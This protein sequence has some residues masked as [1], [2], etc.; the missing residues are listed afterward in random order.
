M[1]K[2]SLTR[3]ALAVL[4]F[5]MVVVTLFA[6][7]NPTSGGGT[8]VPPQT[9]VPVDPGLVVDPEPELVKHSL[10]NQQAMGMVIDSMNRSKELNKMD[11][12]VLDFEFEIFLDLSEKLVEQYY[13]IQVK[14]SIDLEDD[15]KS[16]LQ[17]EIVSQR[18]GLDD[19]IIC[20]FYAKD[21]VMYIDTRGSA[22]PQGIHVFKVE[23][24]DIAWLAGTLQKT[25]DQLALADFM[26]RFEISSLLSGV[27]LGAFT[28]ILSGIIG[29]N[30]PTVITNLVQKNGSYYVENGNGLVTVVMPTILNDAKLMGMVFGVL[31]GVLSDDIFEVIELIFGWDAATIF[32]AA[33]GGEIGVGLFLRAQIQDDSF[34]KMSIG[35]AVND[36][37]PLDIDVGVKDI[38]LGKKPTFSLPDFTNVETKSYSF[39]TLNLDVELNVKISETA[40]PYTIAGIDESFGNLISGL[41]AGDGNSLSFV[42]S[43]GKPIGLGEKEIDVI[44]DV[45]IKLRV[46]LR[47][48]IDLKDNNNTKILLEIIGGQNNSVR[49]GV[50]YIGSEEAAYI[51]L[52]GMGSGRYKVDSYP[53]QK[54]TED[55]N[56]N[57]VQRV[58]YVEDEKG[59]YYLKN[60]EYVTSKKIPSG[61][62]LY[63]QEFYYDFYNQATDAGMKRYT[64]TTT[65]VPLNLTNIIKDSLDELIPTIPS[66]YDIVAGATADDEEKVY[67]EVYAD[68][69]AYI[70][71]LLN[72]GKVMIEHYNTAG[73]TAGETENKIDAIS[74]IKLILLDA[75]ITRGENKMSFDR[76][77]ISLGT[78][79][80]DTLLSA[81]KPGLKLPITKL[82]IDIDSSSGPGLDGI[83]IDAALGDRTAA[84]GSPDREKLSL[85]IKILTEYGEA[86]DDYTMPNVNDPLHP[87]MLL[88]VGK[89]ELGN[90]T[91]L[92]TINLALSGQFRLQLSQG[93]WNLSPLQQVLAGLI[94]QLEVEEDID[95]WYGFD[96]SANLN[97]ATIKNDTLGSIDAKIAIT[98]NPGPNQLPAIIV[99]LVDGKLYIDAEK[100]GIPKIMLD[101]SKIISKNVD[102][103]KN[104]PSG[105]L[106]TA[107]AS[108]I[109]IVGLLAGILGGVELDGSNG[110]QLEV[111]LATNL[112][113]A[114]IGALVPD[115]GADAIA[116][117]DQ[118]RV[119]E[120]SGIRLYL[121]GLNLSELELNVQLGLETDEESID[122]G[123]GLGHIFLGMGELDLVP[124]NASSYSDILSELQVYLGV[125]GS[126][127]IELA[128]GEI[129]LNNMIGAL[130][131]DLASGARFNPYIDVEEDI[132]AGIDLKVQASLDLLNAPD[133]NNTQIVIEA[134]SIRTGNLLLGAYYENAN[135][136]ADLS[137]LGFEKFC[138]N[139]DLIE[140]LSGAIGGTGELEEPNALVTA[141][142]KAK[143]NLQ[144]L[145]IAL[146]LSKSGLQ[147]KVVTGLTGLIVSLIADSI[148]GGDTA[149][150]WMLA[151]LES[152]GMPGFDLPEIG[153]SV[154]IDL[155]RDSGKP[156]LNAI[157]IKIDVTASKELGADPTLSIGLYLGGIVLDTKLRDVVSESGIERSQFPKCGMLDNVYIDV[158]GA[159]E[160]GAYASDPE[161]MN[162]SL[163]DYMAAFA[164]SMGPNEKK[165]E[166]G[167]PVLDADG[168]P[169]IEDKTALYNL[170]CAI[171]IKFN[172]A[173]DL[174]DVIGFRIAGNLAL[175]S[176]LMDGDNMMPK[177]PYLI[178]GSELA[179][180]LYNGIVGKSKKIIGIYLS[181]GYVYVHLNGN[182]LASSKLKL[183]VAG[184]DVLKTLDYVL[185]SKATENDLTYSE[186]FV[187]GSYN[188]YVTKNKSYFLVTP[189]NAEAY[190]NVKKYIKVGEEYVV[191]KDATAEQKKTAEGYVAPTYNKYIKDTT[192]GY[193]LLTAANAT[194]YADTATYPRY[195]KMVIGSKNESQG[196]S[197]AADVDVRSIGGLLNGAIRNISI[198]NH[199]ISINLG[200]NLLG[201]VIGMAMNISDVNIP[202]LNEENSYIKWDYGNPEIYGEGVKALQIS[203]G[204]DPIY[205]RISLGGFKFGM[206]KGN[207]LPDELLEDIAYDANPDNTEK[208]YTSLLDLSNISLSVEVG[209]D[210]ELKESVIPVGGILSALDPLL[211]LGLDLDEG[212]LDINV[213]DDINY[214]LRIYVQTNFNL[215]D[216]N[217]SQILLEIMNEPVGEAKRKVLGVY[218]DGL[219]INPA[220]TEGS[221]VSKYLDPV[222]YIDSDVLNIAKF[223]LENFDLLGALLQGELD[224]LLGKLNKVLA[225]GASAAADEPMTQEEV[226]DILFSLSEHNIKIILTESIIVGLLK[227]LAPDIASNEGV[228][229]VIEELRAQASVEIN[230][231]P[232]KLAVRIDTQYLALG[233]HI[234]EPRVSIDPIENIFEIALANRDQYVSF[235]QK[236]LSV[237]I[238]LAIQYKFFVDKGP[239]NLTSILEDLAMNLDGTKYIE[240]K[241]ATT[242]NKLNAE[243]LTYNRYAK[244]S[245]NQY[246]L[247]ANAASP[248]IKTLGSD[249][250]WSY[251]L[252]S[253]ASDEQKLAAEGF[254]YNTYVK[255]SD[256][257]YTKT[258]SYSP[259]GNYLKIS[260]SLAMVR[261]LLNAINLNVELPDTEGEIR[262][263]LVANILM[264]E[265]YNQILVSQEVPAEGANGN[266]WVYGV[267]TGVKYNADAKVAIGDG[268][269]WIGG[270]PTTVPYNKDDTL[271][272][273]S[274]GNWF[275]KK[276]DS[277]TKKETLY[278]TGLPYV[279]DQ[280]GTEGNGNW[281]IDGVDTG[282]AKR[283]VDILGCLDVGVFISF[284]NGNK[285]I[286]LSLKGGMLYV[287]IEDI[288]G[289][290]FKLNLL[291]LIASIKGAGSASAQGNVAVS[292][293]QEVA[294]AAAVNVSDILNNAISDITIQKG[295]GLD[296]TL[297]YQILAA[298]MSSLV[299]N[300]FG[301]DSLKH[302][303]LVDETT[304]SSAYV[305]IG[306][307]IEKD[308]KDSREYVKL[309]KVADD[310]VLFDATNPDHAAITDCR[311]ELYDADVHGSNPAIFKKVRHSGISYRKYHAPTGGKALYVGFAFAN[312]FDLGIL[313]DG[314]SIGADRKA[315]LASPEEDFV[316]VDS[317][318]T[319]KLTIETS[320]YLEFQGKQEEVVE[321]GNLL[322]SILEQLHQKKV[323]E[324]S[325]KDGDIDIRQLGDALSAAAPAIVISQFYNKVAINVKAALVLDELINGKGFLNK[326]KSSEFAIQ[327]QSYNED[328]TLKDT[329]LGLY[330]ADQC[331]Y[332]ERRHDTSPIIR[333]DLAKLLADPTT[334]GGGSAEADTNALVPTEGASEATADTTKKGDLNLILKTNGLYIEITTELVQAILSSLLDVEVDLTNSVGDLS[335]NLAIT[336]AK[337][338]KKAID[339]NE[340]GV[341]VSI[342]LASLRLAIG[343][344]GLTIG[345]LNENDSILPTNVREDAIPIEE[346]ILDVS[347]KVGLGVNIPNNVKISDV[348]KM[349]N[350]DLDF[351]DLT[352]DV[353]SG[354]FIGLVISVDASLNFGNLD[355]SEAIVKITTKIGKSAT[356]VDIV[357]IYLK[358]GDVYADLSNLLG[359]Q[360]KGKI[361]GLKLSDL[362]GANSIFDLIGGA[363]A[364]ASADHGLELG[365]TGSSIAITITE[366]MVKIL[367]GL[368]LPDS[369][370]ANIPLSAFLEIQYLNDEGKLDLEINL[371]ATISKLL[372]VDLSIY[373]INFDFRAEDTDMVTL[374]AD[375]TTYP[376]VIELGMV[377]QVN[378]EGEPI[379]ENGKQVT[380]FGIVSI[381]LKS[382]SIGLDIS[383]NSLMQAGA[384]YSDGTLAGSTVA[385]NEIAFTALLKA[386]FGDIGNLYGGMFLYDEE[387]NPATQMSR[388]LAL[389]INAEIN[390]AG[391]IEI[392]QSGDIAK[393]IGELLQNINASIELVKKVSV[394]SG[395]V[396]V[397]Q[398]ED[399][400]LGI[401]LESGD[402]YVYLEGLGMANIH[403]EH[404]FI[405]ELISALSSGSAANDN[406]MV[407]AEEKTSN[408]DIGALLSG[409]IKS[410]TL[411]N[412]ALTIVLVDDFIEPLLKTL[413]PDSE[414]VQGLD[415]PNFGAYANGNRVMLDLGAFTDR[416]KGLVAI[417]LQF[418]GLNV[419]IDVMAPTVGLHDANST[420]GVKSHPI[421]TKNEWVTLGEGTNK[422]SAELA[423]CLSLGLTGNTPATGTRLGDILGGI[424]G[425]L[426]TRLILDHDFII[427]IDVKASLELE[428]DLVNKTFN[429]SQ[430]DLAVLLSKMTSNTPSETDELL[431]G[432][433]Y[434]D[435]NETAYIDA[436]HFFQKY[437]NGS[438]NPFVNS[439]ATGKIAIDGIKITDL[440]KSATAS[441]KADESNAMV[442]GNGATAAAEPNADKL[443]S[444][445]AAWIEFGPD[446]ML[447]TVT[448]G[449]IQQ[450]LALA[451]PDT[452]LDGMLPNAALRVDARVNPTQLLI[453]VDI[454]DKAYNDVI[455]VQI[456]IYGFDHD[457]HGGAKRSDLSVHNE[458]VSVLNGVDLTVGEGGFRKIATLDI[459]SLKEKDIANGI[460][461]P[462]DVL[463][464]SLALKLGF[465]A[466]QMAGD[467]EIRDWSKYLA[468]IFGMDASE[469]DILIDILGFEDMASNSEVKI[470]IDAAINL[471]NLIDGFKLAGTEIQV[472]IETYSDI[473]SSSLH[474]NGES[475]KLIITLIG[476]E[477][478]GKSGIY[479][480]F[481]NYRN[482]GK[483]KISLDLMGLIGG[484]GSAEADTGILGEQVFNIL[485]GLIASVELA[486]GK[487]S[488]NLAQNA[489]A[490]VFELLLP[491][492]DLGITPPMG[493]GV[494]IDFRN[495]YI[496][497]NLDF[498]ELADDN[499]TPR[500]EMMRI[501]LGVG[502]ISLNTPDSY[503]GGS[504]IPEI[505]RAEYK[506]LTKLKID[507]DLLGELTYTGI[508]SSAATPPV[509]LSSLFKLIKVKGQPL[510][511]NPMFQLRIANNMGTTY[512]I[513]THIHLDLENF[514][515]LKISL[516]VWDTADPDNYAL[517]IGAYIDGYD[518]YLDLSSLG[519]PRIKL[520]G[521]NL[522]D[523][524]GNALGGLLGG[525]SASASANN[526]L[527]TS[528]D[529]G[530]LGD[531]ILQGYPLPYIALV[532]RP[533]VFAIGINAKMIDAIVKMATGVESDEPYLPDFGDIAIIGDSRTFFVPEEDA[534]EAEKTNIKDRYA[535]VLLT[536]GNRAQYANNSVY[537]KVFD[538]ALPT[539]YNYIIKGS[540]KP[541]A[542]LETNVSGEK[543]EYVLVPYNDI[544]AGTKYV[545]IGGKLLPELAIRISEGFY[546]TIKLN[547]VHING[548]LE[549]ANW[550]TA[551]EVFDDRIG[552]GAAY[553]ADWAEAYNIKTGQIGLEKVNLGLDIGLH[554]YTQE[555]KYGDADYAD[556]F[557]FYLSNLLSSLL[558]RHAA[559]ENGTSANPY[560]ND[561]SFVLNT[562]DDVIGYILKVRISADLSKLITSTGFNIAGLLESEILLE[563]HIDG[564]FT[565]TLVLGVYKQANDDAFYLDLKQLGLPKIKLFGLGALLA[566]I[567][568]AASDL[569]NYATATEDVTAPP[570][571]AEIA[572]EN[573][574]IEIALEMEVLRQLFKTLGLETADMYFQQGSTV[575]KYTAIVLRDETDNVKMQ[576][577]L[578][579]LDTIRL[580]V[581][582]AG[583][584]NS[585]SLEIGLD[586]IGTVAELEIGN[587]NVSL[588]EGFFTTEFDKLNGD[589][590]DDWGA[591]VLSDINGVS[592][593]NIVTGAL[594]GLDLDLSISLNKKISCKTVNGTGGMSGVTSSYTPSYT[595]IRITRTNG[596]ST[597]ADGKN[598]N[599][600]LVYG[601]KLAVNVDINNNGSTR[602]AAVWLFNNAIYGDLGELAGGLTGL[603]S[604]FYDLR[605][606]KFTDLNIAELVADSGTT[607]TNTQIADPN[608]KLPST[609]TASAEEKAPVLDTIKNYIKGIQI[610]WWYNT[611]VA[612]YGTN[613]GT[614]GDTAISTI[615]VDLAPQGINEL[616]CF[617]YYLLFGLYKAG[618]IDNLDINNIPALTNDGYIGM[619]EFKKLSYAT[620]MQIVQNSDGSVTSGENI[621]V[622]E[623]G[624]KCTDAYKACPYYL[625]KFATVLV[626]S[627]L[628]TTALNGILGN[629]LA[630]G[631]IITEI[632][633]ALLPIP[634]LDQNKP[635]YVEIVLDKNSP[636][637]ILREVG[638][639]INAQHYKYSAAT[640]VA[641]S[642]TITKQ[643]VADVDTNVD[644]G[645]AEVLIQLNGIFMRSVSGVNWYNNIE[646]EQAERLGITGV[647]SSNTNPSSDF[648]VGTKAYLVA[649]A[650]NP[651]ELS[652]SALNSPTALPQRVEATFTNYDDFVYNYT[653]KGDKDAMAGSDNDEKA[654]AELGGTKIIWDVSHVNLV[655]GSTDSYIYGYALNKL[656]AK[657]P[658]KVGTSTGYMKVAGYATGSTAGRMQLTVSDKIVINN[659]KTSLSEKSL[660][661][662]PSVILIQ[663]NNGEYML[664]SNDC[665]EAGVWATKDRNIVPA[666]AYDVA[667]INNSAYWEF[668]TNGATSVDLSTFTKTGGTYVKTENGVEQKYVLN[669][670]TGEYQYWV[671][672]TKAMT[673]D[674]I[675]SFV[676][677]STEVY[678]FSSYVYD[679]DGNRVHAMASTPYVEYNGKRIHA[680]NG[681]FGWIDGDKEAI[682]L[683]GDI[684]TSFWYKSGKTAKIDVSTT[685]EY[686]NNNVVRGYLPDDEEKFGVLNNGSAA[687]MTAKSVNIVENISAIDTIRVEFTS[688]EI[689]TLSVDKSK[690]Q[691]DFTYDAKKYYKGVKGNAIATVTYYNADGSLA[692]KQIKIPINVSSYEVVGLTNE[693]VAYSQYDEFTKENILP[694]EFSI[695]L[696]LSAVRT[697]A[698]TCN[699]DDIKVYNSYDAAGNPIYDTL[700]L[701]KN[702]SVDSNMSVTVKGE[703]GKEGLTKQVFDFKVQITSK[704]VETVY[705]AVHKDTN[706]TSITTVTAGFADGT[707]GTLDIVGDRTALDNL[708][709]ANGGIF[710]I[711]LNV[712][713]TGRPA[714]FNQKVKAVVR[715]LRDPL[716][717][718][719]V[720]YSAEMENIATAESEPTEVEA[721]FDGEIVFDPLFDTLGAGE[722][723][724]ITVGGATKEVVLLKSDKIVV[725]ADSSADNV[726]RS[727][728]GGVY[729]NATLWFVEA[730]VTNTVYKVSNSKLIVIDRQI[731]GDTLKFAT[732]PTFNPYFYDPNP[733]SKS[734]SFAKYATT[735]VSFKNGT[736][737]T[738]AVNWNNTDVEYNS[739]AYKDFTAVAYYGATAGV[740]KNVGC[741]VSAVLASKFEPNIVVNKTFKV[742]PLNEDGTYNKNFDAR[743]LENYPTSVTI[744]NYYQGEALTLNL[745]WNLSTLKYKYN[746]TSTPVEVSVGNEKGGYQ[747]L[748]ITLPIAPFV[749]DSD[750][751]WVNDGVNDATVINALQSANIDPFTYSFSDAIFANVSAL[752]NITV[753]ANGNVDSSIADVKW[754]IKNIKPTYKGG[755]LAT[756]ALFFKYELAG[757]QTR[758][759]N[760]KFV[761]REL[762]AVYDDNNQLL[763]DLVRTI[764][765]YDQSVSL[766]NTVNAYFKKT[767]GSD[768]TYETVSYSTSDNG[769]YWSKAN[770]RPSASGEM[771]SIDCRLTNNGVTIVHPMTYE[772]DVVTANRIT[773]WG[774][775]NVVN[776]NINNGVIDAPWVINPLD[777]T[778][779][780]H[781]PT[782][783]NVK[784]VFDTYN[785]G[786]SIIGTWSLGVTSFTIADDGAGNKTVVYK[787]SE[788]A[789]PK[790][791]TWND[792]NGVY[793]YEI[794]NSKGVFDFKKN[795]DRYT[796]NA[797]GTFVRSL[798][799]VESKGTYTRV[800]ASEGKYTYTLT[801]G[802]GAGAVTST[803]TDI[804]PDANN[805]Y[806]IFKTIDSNMVITGLGKGKNFCKTADTHK[807]ESAELNFGYV[808]INM[809][810]GYKV[811]LSG[812]DYEALVELGKG[813]RIKLNVKVLDRTFT[814]TAPTIA[815]TA[816]AGAAIELPNSINV[817]FN[818]TYDGV[819]N[820][821]TL[822][823]HWEIV[824]EYL[825]TRNTTAETYVYDSTYNQ[826]RVG[827][828]AVTREISYNTQSISTVKKTEYNKA[829]GTININ[830]GN[831]DPC[832]YTINGYVGRVMDTDNYTVLVDSFNSDS[833]SPLYQN[834][835]SATINVGNY[836]NIIFDSQ[837]TGVWITD[838]EAG[839]RQYAM[840]AFD[841]DVS[842]SMRIVTGYSEG[843]T[844][845]TTNKTATGTFELDRVVIGGN[846]YAMRLENNKLYVKMAI[847]AN[848]DISA[849]ETETVFQRK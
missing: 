498:H 508:R 495:L 20:G 783:K 577:P 39:T 371:N 412:K 713:K 246:I 483:H 570:A 491:D 567:G 524:L 539:G 70:A 270:K 360:A 420:S 213:K 564:N 838:D 792:T 119:T 464:V 6:A 238:D 151:I 585:I 114:L 781:Y 349:F 623:R 398:P 192:L 452:D 563:L 65:Q 37:N 632:I 232:F 432:I 649:D 682:S 59:K 479:I 531:T 824:K 465:D 627:L 295:F 93:N 403:I 751:A 613:T 652:S 396:T 560:L 714:A 709:F 700:T 297:N 66:L 419:G 301:A 451:L 678:N 145:Q 520:G 278:D 392:I 526:A 337:E 252:E 729:D 773:Q 594:D 562:P 733:S 617:V 834:K 26:N 482:K 849:S 98:K 367:L 123:I 551:Q 575:Q 288:G 761:E 79:V 197:A 323:K 139:I 521:V 840:L 523:I 292:T 331:L 328:G 579:N 448:M 431:L 284:D 801:Y 610:N 528:S 354:A 784:V 593:G 224:G 296:V 366:E 56:G 241:S 770:F 672:S 673:A 107:E 730:G 80:I 157:S 611:S 325:Y 602:H 603:V 656:V 289:Q 193:V 841:K 34:K 612:V 280:K 799:G 219:I 364:S 353:G 588:G 842:K 276:V 306:D 97:L 130:L 779:T 492:Q 285:Q 501:S 427:G 264:E 23:N 63:S 121:D 187:A 803:L 816:T 48:E 229:Q 467:G 600:D 76:I 214:N 583:K 787:A 666:A 515:N 441:A 728:A 475:G 748:N 814:Y 166:N 324:G 552:T 263:K 763:I 206:T 407:T 414:Y 609:E 215:Q 5:L 1:K 690:W 720:A 271:E 571:F 581:D 51:D 255:K 72:S 459:D 212:A 346:M 116:A 163:K 274:N 208:R 715:V 100:I 318:T 418:Y 75:E 708:N 807:G 681:S 222:L 384:E 764:N 573:G 568:S 639:H 460:K 499:V 45:I 377:P 702:V 660:T 484:L 345:I 789:T 755:T 835:F 436:S 311:Y 251:V 837:F 707:V 30:V 209:L 557:Q 640:P 527:S 41:L 176:L 279:K 52:S 758:N 167:N 303:Y 606:M 726:I 774:N 169:V 534:S 133:Y 791:G 641:G 61:V 618:S 544:G 142:E 186:G 502:F 812:G 320:I 405:V 310:Y 338:G 361:T 362:L 741:R 77:F 425:D 746:S 455:G 259:N 173:S 701:P 141:D 368:L 785:F 608:A 94:L 831:A 113:S 753:K 744:D 478:D 586:S 532:F 282:I 69:A 348:L 131:V 476:D 298:L 55:A 796:F 317:A 625:Q 808:G 106:A 844:E 668:Y 548:Y 401:Y 342:N 661:A 795:Y 643:S 472:T 525:S 846:T 724:T 13:A 83:Y 790:I 638:I 416:T 249:Q 435:V 242:E 546:G 655:P 766:P 675:Y 642:T 574:K 576:I 633:T 565:N 765:V 674:G 196:A 591:I 189:T 488:V 50:Y 788:T 7:C 845:T 250:T 684:E 578:P 179:I 17:I 29:G 220:W 659:E 273:G 154:S 657:V 615:R 518:V 596:D 667:N 185:E 737:E 430:L 102:I 822:P 347:L 747:K 226:I 538:E 195:I 376:V 500:D 462:N 471:A 369:A 333:I 374:P 686:V 140:L 503:A 830:N 32:S 194:Q 590:A 152:E 218:F 49:A 309:V 237:T 447:V 244:A 144:G 409:I 217:R 537:Y 103:F 549:N 697:E 388:E 243:G 128:E 811:T 843:G 634:L 457:E 772:T 321:L 569:F 757:S 54:F 542:N 125:E 438:E 558:G 315:V 703:Y 559:T 67:D 827:D 183:N 223:K 216:V 181:G 378:A 754:N 496:G 566:G 776:W 135:L 12:S 620:K 281:Y 671:D 71:S 22:K 646:K 200:A 164:E 512:M 178:E 804:A 725:V 719:S 685:V 580:A 490:A 696:K 168:N 205:L 105:A 711:E 294:A 174:Y 227:A 304:D 738:V 82:D 592:V 58:R 158:I 268:F 624:I 302:F 87:Y 794:E 335:A 351:G 494:F 148:E 343:L 120:D 4:L 848:G 359:P 117:L 257:E 828:T 88:N 357:S 550:E 651:V 555:S 36:E 554:F 595:T 793:S 38:V 201:A 101:L 24:L 705:L 85:G 110:I 228:M 806:K 440:I 698:A 391:L 474:P 42:D 486:D 267:D 556:S 21:G 658:V 780:Q 706:P 300:M 598:S 469:F 692:T 716:N 96:I 358:G 687:D 630:V 533:E 233:V 363:S 210:I 162:Y 517:M 31:G 92:S 645:N 489:L 819:I 404:G 450:I 631:N 723:Y 619:A 587:F 582:I 375:H 262:I 545:K 308:I 676:E 644:V 762:L 535:A 372:G 622:A 10:T 453:N 124:S 370:L 541:T 221:D 95:M 341:E 150:D 299:P 62:T 648:V 813:D 621:P 329:I 380:K 365:F 745:V 132:L 379:I 356:P 160:L 46:K 322:E 203:L 225:G 180:E 15:S 400:L 547:D 742:Y 350:S 155:G 112:L 389:Q 406:A 653:S 327:I 829:S 129:D 777:A 3:K 786:D 397:S 153:A 137:A 19:K 286:V 336:W 344:K 146:L 312:G 477:G 628:N 43:N 507:I 272:Q 11:A 373:D 616:L 810:A 234:A 504:F 847:S 805:V 468:G 258:V 393:H 395:G 319:G 104:I 422:F 33:Q 519:I 428:F 399:V 732:A 402:V 670:S 727:V 699:R 826:L 752:N 245:E 663:Q 313:I 240:I 778:R 332:V 493:G 470:T 385:E 287:D 759:V 134:R 16:L 513:N 572:I 511:E 86:M 691:F 334:V 122:L 734:F 60:G 269:W 461:F 170:L 202:V 339:L 614:Y 413:L 411:A 126:L 254:S 514:N 769:V 487:L 629:N 211:K 415:I 654:W 722:K 177:L 290:N 597:R 665:K 825:V 677:N 326:I 543:L 463:N 739:S 136:Y 2:N 57:V 408:I 68:E 750:F 818:K 143:V 108:D 352:V 497:V 740:S 191:E 637:G 695:D 236:S 798:Y 91:G 802:E 800:D 442:A 817:N 355:A 589:Y 387:G 171:M 473:F 529:E 688:G 584:I 235:D 815:N 390:L 283:S 767:V 382:V 81:L 89:D 717:S 683:G 561:G 821:A 809:P 198:T 710:E 449:L 437:V 330:L 73:A 383:L 307:A 256:T 509:D 429:I 510:L 64:S 190:A 253:Q 127:T 669:S 118:V 78:D 662:L 636:M 823:V 771:C 516:E 265:L 161:I 756:P 111:K 434:S 266:W 314:Y 165:D 207:V 679:V 605:K 277:E 44:N 99:H 9:E 109:D 540:E 18:T 768:I 485:N 199:S 426:D 760:V 607:N 650:F 260:D 261:K 239:V 381:P 138:M 159:I 505:E 182:I 553:G 316:S 797:D 14:G 446:T 147:A 8:F 230:T 522:G 247:S 664:L 454:L 647:S 456:G 291:D 635:S 156:L 601:G 718:N 188:R 820:P 704:K 84:E 599:G 782:S 694:S 712:G 680:T 743:L 481:S 626:G 25:F 204:I 833:T 417:D 305:E 721:T 736:K 386:F 731:S 836:S 423:L 340:V 506:D 433:Y 689:R 604:A 248:Y 530:G 693:T 149:D 27:D 445:A 175:D 394:V 275:I 839:F 458:Y 536:A 231:V 47:A 184:L 90:L 53:R 28:S 35:I 480:D 749:L 444:A 421:E 735:V 443:I 439:T 115:I 293:A 410:I 832:Y 40:K 424:V 466:Q 775:G 74:I 172:V